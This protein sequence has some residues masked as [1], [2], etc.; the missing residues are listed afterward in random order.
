MHSNASFWLVLFALSATLPEVITA[1][2][3][4]TRPTAIYTPVP[5]PP[6]MS[7]YT[8][9]WFLDNAKPQYRPI[10]N[11][12]PPMERLR[13]RC[14]F[15]SSGLSD[16]ARRIAPPL[17]LI[18]IWDVWEDWLYNGDPVDT[19]PLRNIIRTERVPVIDNAGNPVMDTTVTPPVPKMKTK[20]T[21]VALTYFS[22]MSLA[23]AHICSGEIRSI[24]KDLGEI[25]EIGIF[26]QVELRWLQR[27][28]KPGCQQFPVSSISG[29]QYTDCPVQGP[30]VPL[31]TESV[32][33]PYTPGKSRR[34]KRGDPDS[35]S[36]AADKT[37]KLW[38][39][40]DDVDLYSVGGVMDG[41]FESI[42]NLMETC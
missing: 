36:S 29:T 13:D 4:S 28:M 18:T 1:Q 22:R 32:G 23:F 39:S 12:M 10:L 21:G 35:D 5:L 3:T 15:Y 9:Q 19:N 2:T 33:G 7:K 20:S 27:K 31:E 24:H 26:R 11:R 8:V 41:L 17:G 14:L 40:V 6:E 30:S 37:A 42:E 34:L 16:D 25:A 38:A